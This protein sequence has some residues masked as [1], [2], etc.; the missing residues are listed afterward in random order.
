MNGSDV[1]PSLY[2]KTAKIQSGK[3]DAGQIGSDGESFSAGN[4]QVEQDRASFV[5]SHFDE[6][7]GT[8]VGEFG[9]DYSVDW[10]HDES[11]GL[12]SV[13][14][15]RQKYISDETQNLRWRDG[16][17]KHRSKRQTRKMELRH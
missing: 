16:N 3:T 4:E 7:E 9:G 10:Q 13:C 14:D 8:T 17:V 6:L 2:H 5:Q 11:D 12:E 1:C 15:G